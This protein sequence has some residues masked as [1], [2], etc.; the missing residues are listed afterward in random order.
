MRRNVSHGA[1]SFRVSY[2]LNGVNEGKKE[3]NV[4]IIGIT[5]YKILSTRCTKRSKRVI[6]F[7][8]LDQGT[9]SKL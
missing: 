6:P 1:P 9:I 8:H 4:R 3:R 7:S 5:G 2:N